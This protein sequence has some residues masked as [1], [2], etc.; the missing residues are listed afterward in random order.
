MIHH[1]F[2]WWVCTILDHLHHK[3]QNCLLLFNKTFFLYPNIWK[4]FQSTYESLNRHILQWQLWHFLPRERA[5]NS[6]K[7]THKLQNEYFNAMQSIMYW[8]NTIAHT[9][10]HKYV[11]VFDIHYSRRMCSKNHPTEYEWQCRLN[12]LNDHFW[13]MSTV[14]QLLLFYLKKTAT[15]ER[16]NWNI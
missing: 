14:L 13:Q 5:D 3:V 9:H 2:H 15:D 8:M 4:Q 10:T 6:L 11:E 12:P 16:I 1:W 7:Q